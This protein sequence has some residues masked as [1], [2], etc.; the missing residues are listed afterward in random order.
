M[1]CRGIPASVPLA[2]RFVRSALAHSPR[3]DDLELIAAELITNAIRHTPS[4]REGG[5]FAITIRR[6]LGRARLEV[7]D[8]GNGPWRQPQPDGDDMAEHGWGLHIVA[9]LADEIG[10]RTAVGG[11]QV[12]WADV[13]WLPS[14]AI[15]YQLVSSGHR[16]LEVNGDHCARPGDEGI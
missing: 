4:G 14:P 2:R 12:M 15:R 8:Q 11:G 5:T 3:I 16:G 9:A 7:A 13:I 1:T 10:H 6:Q